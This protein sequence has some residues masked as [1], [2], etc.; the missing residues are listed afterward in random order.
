M[1]PIPIDEINSLEWAVIHRWMKP[2][3]KHITSAYRDLRD[4]A[5]NDLEALFAAASERKRTGGVIW[6]REMFEREQRSERFL[7]QFDMMA[8]STNGKLIDE[9]RDDWK[10]VYTYS[11]AEGYDI[12]SNNLPVISPYSIP[13]SRAINSMINRVGGDGKALSM[14]FADISFDSLNVMRRDLVRAVGMGWGIEKT[15]RELLVHGLDVGEARAK[16]IAR[17]EIMRASNESLKDL[18]NENSD[19]VKG[20]VRVA[21]LDDRTCLACSM[22]DGKFYRLDEMMDDH[23]NGR[24][25]FVPET[26]TWAE[27][28]FDP[29]IDKDYPP[30][31][32][33]RRATAEYERIKR[34]GQSSIYRVTHTG[35]GKYRNGQEW[36]LKQPTHIK[37][38][39]MGSKIN[40][41]LWADRGSKPDELWAFVGKNK[42]MWVVNN[43]KRAS[44]LLSKWDSS[45]RKVII[46]GER[47][48]IFKA[49][50]YKTMKK[51]S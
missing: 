17:T 20:M 35:I 37:Q 6:N 50:K 22:L 34:P 4:R 9:L 43:N 28:G 25:I 1:L 7:R 23:V 18:Y 33:Q 48:E 40:Y 32:K 11:H 16:R 44:E 5:K 39:V 46:T 13:D 12:L 8:A 21:A 51:A 42:G 2:S 10:A 19:V 49:G 41:Q 45:G 47:L 29:M 26:K 31:Q 30:S 24:C 27:L 15:V 36:F 14:R 3:D 38:Q